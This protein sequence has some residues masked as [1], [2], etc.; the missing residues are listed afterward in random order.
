MSESLP[1]N[2]EVPVSIPGFTV[3]IFPEGEDSRGDHGLGRTLLALHPPISPLASSGQ[4]NCASWTSQ[5]QKTVT[6][7]PCPAPR[8]PRGHV[9]ALDKKNIILYY[10]ILYLYI[11]I[12][13][14]NVSFHIYII[15]VIN[16]AISYILCYFIL[17]YI[18][19]AI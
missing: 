17:Y 2:H 18:T 3:G 13:Y 7:L 16:H 6:L 19:V 11:I 4:R 12:I 1:T 5:P 8:S 14:H 15:Y 9:G 10:V